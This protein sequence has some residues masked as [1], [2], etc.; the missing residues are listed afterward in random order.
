MAL[1]NSRH[2]EF[3]S[4]MVNSGLDPP[5]RLERSAPIHPSRQKKEKFK[6]QTRSYASRVDLSVVWKHWVRLEINMRASAA[7]YVSARA[8]TAV[9]VA[10]CGHHDHDQD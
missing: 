9:E 7:K 5:Y 4:R 8:I 6:S 3:V 1:L 2:A 10:A